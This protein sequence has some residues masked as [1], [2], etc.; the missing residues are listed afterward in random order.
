MKISKYLDFIKEN[1][2]SS[3]NISNNIFWTKEKCSLEALKY[4]NKRDFK[5][6]N[7]S[8]YCASLRNKWIDEICGHMDI[9]KRLNYWTKDKCKEEALK[10]NTKSEFE[11]GSPTAYVKSGKMG[12]KDEICSHM[13]SNGN[14]YNRCVYAI[15]FSDN[16]CYIG[17]SYN[18][19]KRLSQHLTDYKNNT[20]VL[21]HYK[22]TGITPTIKQLTDYI[23][24][25]DASKIEPL[26]VKEY[27]DNGWNVLNVAKCGNVGGK[28]IKWTK[29]KCFDEASKYKTRNEFKSNSP[30]SYHAARRNKWI[31]DICSHMY[32]KLTKW[33]YKSCEEESKKFK[34]R[35]DFKKKSSGAFGYAYKN[36]LLDTL[37]PQKYNRI[38][39]NMN[40]NYYL[41]TY[42]ECVELCSYDGSPFYET[43]LVVDGYP[44]SLFNYRLASYNDFLVKPFA[45]EMR[46]ICFCFNTDGSIF[47]RY[48]LLEKFFNLNQVSDTMYSVVKNYKIK[49]VNNKEDGS[50]ASF[51]KIPNGKVVGKSKMGFDNDQAIGI[52]RIY[53][54]N[55]DVKDLVDWCLDN[56]IDS[57]WEYVSPTNRIVLRYPKEELILLRFRDNKTGKHID[58]KDHLDKIGSIKIAPFEDDHTLD[59]L[60]ELSKTVK[61]KEGWVIQFDNG[62]FMKVKTDD[63][64]SKHGLLTEDL[65]K[66]NKIIGY[67]LDDK[68]DDILGQIPEDEVEAHERINKI[69]EIVKKSINDKML[70]IQ[71]FYD[72]YKNSG[73]SIKDFALKYRKNI[74]FGYVMGMLRADKLKT[75]SEKEISDLYDNLE[76][77]ETS[78][79]RGDVYELAKSWIRDNTFRLMEAREWLRKIEPT[80][81]EKENPTDQ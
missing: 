10:Y 79:K 28:T 6:N 71:K 14:K 58:I 38:S 70:E 69:I 60:I 41:P 15:E 19:L 39:E 27:L 53:N 81:F 24:V 29:E 80:Y 51:I 72:F 11:K 75:L 55:K 4:Q 37:F 1:I 20:V 17:L 2:K 73:L 5:N 3:N 52:N 33:D 8:A 16:Y 7:R 48:V 77:Y 31:D 36:N 76:D 26:K 22:K 49:Y 59:G 46:G 67:I 9:L 43:K 65:Y 35:D 32:F 40:N 66:E 78:I 54:S 30:L 25:E 63:Y 62:K 56:N 34:N 50:I 23:N 57:I 61:D 45:Q 64:N 74:N 12:W 42:D 47:N 13:L 68:I 18:Y 44:V 21:K